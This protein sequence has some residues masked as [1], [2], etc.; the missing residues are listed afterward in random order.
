MGWKGGVVSVRNLVVAA[1]N[2]GMGIQGEEFAWR[3]ADK[4]GPDPDGDG[5]QRE[6]SVGDVTAIT[7]YIAAQEA[8]TGVGHLAELG[9]VAA[10]DAAAKERI[11]R[12]SELFVKI[13]CTGCHLPE[14]HLDNTVFEE[15]TSASGGSYL[16]HFLASKDPDYD[17]KR[18]VKIDLL[19]DSQE[20][21]IEADP[22]G[23]AIVRLYGDLKRHD[24]GRRLADPVPGA[25]LDA[26]L[27]PLSIGGKI[28]LIS[29]SEFLTTELWGVGSTT[30]YLHDDRAG[31][32]A[33]A[34]ELHGEDE[35]PAV[36]APGRS[37][38]QEARDAYMKLTPDER[39]AVVTFLKSL[40]NFSKEGV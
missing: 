16:D 31:T 5:V 12:G 29:P 9:L 14:M 33:E 19:K 13:G 3:V 40:V 39:T 36:G 20:P 4:A 17:P 28:A 6:L 8:P 37:E 21:R 7:T 34:I 2:F 35:P 27:A 23:G 10:P 32:L 38:A 25:P 22:K 26:S 1:A 24:M 15:P 11:D 30:P 18:P